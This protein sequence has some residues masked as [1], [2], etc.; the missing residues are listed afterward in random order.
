ML[1][2]FYGIISRAATAA[3]FKGPPGISTVQSGESL[4]SR[5]SLRIKRFSAEADEPLGDG[6]GVGGRCRV[7]SAFGTH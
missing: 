6:G 1:S 4:V 2:E 7:V 3:I 5:E